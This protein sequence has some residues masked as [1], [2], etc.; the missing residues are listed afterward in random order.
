MNTQVNKA[1]LDEQ[2]P[3]LGAPHLRFL[4]IRSHDLPLLHDKI[5]RG[6]LNPQFGGVT[7]AFALMVMKDPEHRNM[8]FLKYGAAVCSLKDRYTK[9]QGRKLAA[10]RFSQMHLQPEAFSD[11][12]FLGFGVLNH[13]SLED[14]QLRLS[15]GQIPFSLKT[16]TPLYSSSYDVVLGH[17]ETHGHPEV[18]ADNVNIPEILVSEVS[19]KIVERHVRCR[20]HNEFFAD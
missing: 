1:T 10:L 16:E 17:P 2:T 5:Q 15:L 13:G 20:L 11:I 8:L 4:H 9:D 19:D 18:R 14:R 3:S 6:D 12:V 7:V